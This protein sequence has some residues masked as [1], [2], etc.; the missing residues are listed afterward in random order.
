MRLERSRK[1]TPLDPSIAG[2]PVEQ[3]NLRQAH[4]GFAFDLAVELHEGRA[5]VLRERRA[6][7]AFAGAAQPDQRDALLARRLLVAEF[8]QQSRD[9]VMETVFR[10]SVE[11]TPD[12]SLLGRARTRLDEL[13]HRQAECACDAAQK[14]HRRVALSRF[15]L[16]EIAL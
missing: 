11:E 6:E 3:E 8:A 13:G 10:Q 16:G 5:V 9:D 1:A 12:Q 15:E 4:G 7:R 2:L 14:Q